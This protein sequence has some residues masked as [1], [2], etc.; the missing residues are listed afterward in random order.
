MDRS[1]FFRQKRD[2]LV[3]FLTDLIGGQKPVPVEQDIPKTFLDKL[4]IFKDSKMNALVSCIPKNKTYSITKKYINFVTSKN[5]ETNILVYA[6]LIS[7]SALV[8]CLGSIVAIQSI[9]TTALPPTEADPKYDPMDNNI[10]SE[11]EIEYRDFDK[12]WYKRF[13]EKNTSANPTEMS[14]KHVIL[15][16]IT[17]GITLITLYY[18]IKQDMISWIIMILKYHLIL[19]NFI[20]TLSVYSYLMHLIVLFCSR[21]KIVGG[22]SKKILK[23][24]RFAVSDDDKND[25]SNDSGKFSIGSG[26]ITNFN[27]S[28]KTIEKETLLFQDTI[29]FLNKDGNEGIK[30][31]YFKEF[32]KPKD[33]KS[34]KQILN[35][36]FDWILLISIIISLISSYLFFKYDNNWLICNLIGINISIWSINQFTFKN[37]KIG[38]LIMSV[39]F[40]YDIFF[41]FGTTYMVT[42]AKNLELPIK[43]ILPINETLVENKKKFE[44][45]L[46]GL[47]DI[48]LP[49]AFISMCHKFDIW[50]WHNE[51]IDTEFHLLR[52]NSYFFDGKY[53]I[54]S[55]IAYILSLATC[56]ISLT[57]FKLPQPALLYIVPF[58]ITST[59]ITASYNN[60]LHDFWSLQYDTLVLDNKIFAAGKMENS[61]AEIFEI[62]YEEEESDDHVYTDDDAELLSDASFV[63]DAEIEA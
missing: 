1:D 40:F 62:L 18:L 49:G 57:Y 61:S 45:A 58:L 35:F 6:T 11:C 19:L 50:K 4:L 2:Q 22:N 29:D 30:K 26:F 28:E 52:F 5:G 33:I 24:Y 44:F 39:L 48:I 63:S 15:L 38:V 13:F 56:M 41:V 12:P 10:R 47:G 37:L 16:P 36:Y 23:K 7:I 21:I 17:S 20:S 9:P 54:V 46:L 32:T 34:N 3:G 53:F 27:Y 8:I 59:L 14:E 25:E 55:I 60:D 43:I 42:V 31:T 51:R